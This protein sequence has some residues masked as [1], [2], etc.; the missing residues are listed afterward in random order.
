MSIKSYSCGQ[1]HGIVPATQLVPTYQKVRSRVSYSLRGI[2]LNIIPYTQARS[3]ALHSSHARPSHPSAIPSR[4]SYLGRGGW[5]R[6]LIRHHGDPLGKAELGLCLA[7]ASKYHS[8]RRTC[9]VVAM[10]L[11]GRLLGRL[12]PACRFHILVMHSEAWY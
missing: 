6:P 4:L 9:Q 5:R 1:L 7:L 10:Y 11:L 3:S 2:D 8:L 12:D